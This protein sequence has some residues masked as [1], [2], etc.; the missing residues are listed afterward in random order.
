MKATTNYGAVDK[1]RI[2][3]AAFSANSSVVSS[4]YIYHR[5]AFMTF[6][7]VLSSA[8][9]LWFTRSSGSIDLSIESPG[10]NAQEADIYCSLGEA[11][12]VANVFIGASFRIDEMVDS[13]FVDVH[14]GQYS[15]TE[16]WNECKI[17]YT[18]AVGRGQFDLNDCLSA[19]QYAIDNG[20]KF[21]GHNLCWNGEGYNPAWLVEGN[22]DG[23]Y[24]SED[25][26][27]ILVNHI[28]NVVSNITINGSF[29]Y[30]WDVVNEAIGWN[31]DTK[32]TEIRSDAP[33]SNI[34]S[35]SLS[36]GTTTYEYS[37]YVELAFLAT[38]QFI[39]GDSLLCY[40]DYGLSWSEERFEAVLDLVQNN[41]D[42]IDCLGLEAH[43]NV[44][45]EAW[46]GSCN[47]GGESQLNVTELD[48]FINRVGD[49]GVKLHFTELEVFNATKIGGETVYYP[50]DDS[51]QADIYARYLLKCLEN[52]DVCTVFQTW[53]VTDAVD[54]TFESLPF[55]D[56][57][58]K[59]GAFWAMLLTLNNY[60]R[61]GEN[62][63]SM[64]Q[65]EE[66]CIFGT[67]E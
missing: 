49:L 52:S 54:W 19:F 53:G 43:I 5:A 31:S 39:P 38:K 67:Q 64:Q 14:A 3:D 41:N 58:K 61:L 37:D 9:A 26:A 34:T 29:P 15:L 16:L 57:L 56:E 65:L 63:L 21:R 22:N 42:Y 24:G 20:Q 27:K 32:K 17:K 1:L 50:V 7:L 23:T 10:D 8:C 4:A 2:G 6:I 18:E 28:M 46:K 35:G 62:Q 36:R 11:G 55:D 60:L 12:N 13:D 47:G 44:N 30:A 48:N 33:W 66:K 25:L 40:N 45:C 51:V 59:K